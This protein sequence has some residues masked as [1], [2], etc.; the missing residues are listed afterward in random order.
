MDPEQR[1]AYNADL[2]RSLQDEDD[3]YTGELLSRWCANT[4]MGK[5]EDP[6]E[7][8]GVFVDEVSCIGCKQCVWCAPATFRMEDEYG[9]SRVFGHWLD[10]EDDIQVGGRGG[11]RGAQPGC[12]A[13]TRT[14]LLT[15]DDGPR[16]PAPLLWLR[17]RP[18]WT[19]APSAASTG[20]TRPTCPPS[21]LWCATR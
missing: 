9:R 18:P 12:A 10:K 2:D 13:G 11:D 20:W 4:R 7:S 6:E 1:Q 5:N 17:R 16:L 3:G 15:R 21:S 8:R 19:P 14:C